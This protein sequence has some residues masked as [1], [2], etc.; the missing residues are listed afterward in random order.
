MIAQPDDT[1]ASLPFAAVP[2]LPR[3]AQADELA[4]LVRCMAA[5]EQRAL[6]AFYRATVGRVYGLALR[7]TR[8]P[9]CAEEVAEDV[10]V[11]LW[12]SAIRYTVERGSPLAWALNVCRSRAIDTLRRREPTF[13][14]PEPWRHLP[15]EP[16][17]GSGLQDLLQAAQEHGALHAALQSLR[18]EQRQLVGLAFF[19]GLSHAEMAEHMGQPL[20]TVK[21]QMRRALALLRTQ[22][23]AR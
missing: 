23:D 13:T 14:D 4:A 20:G 1:S 2:I 21:S 15:S 6:E 17:D 22:L 12:H 10:Y 11:Q 3:D 16:A 18:P 8:Q 7:I 9:E 19:R 5:G